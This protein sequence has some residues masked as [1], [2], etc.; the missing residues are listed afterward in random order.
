[1]RCTD[2][3]SAYI[4]N[5]NNEMVEDLQRDFVSVHARKFDIS[6]VFLTAITV[7]KT[8]PNHR[9]FVDYLSTTRHGNRLF[10]PC[11]LHILLCS[12]VFIGS[13]AL[14][15]RLISGH[16][17]S[18]I[19]SLCHSKNGG[20]TIAQTNH[21]Y[22]KKLDNSWYRRVLFRGTFNINIHSK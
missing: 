21:K 8:A 12:S 16:S 14:R 7:Y 20:E 11:E 10:L 15:F 19:C 22:V 2:P 5:W 6:K 1:M 13:L 3:K 18:Y 4:W 17:G 9:G